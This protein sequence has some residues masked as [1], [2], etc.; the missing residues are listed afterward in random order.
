MYNDSV[1][2]L[3]S[4]GASSTSG[5]KKFQKL[6]SRDGQLSRPV[7]DTQDPEALCQLLPGDAEGGP[8]VDVQPEKLR[9]VH[10]RHILTRFGVFTELDFILH[11][12]QLA[13]KK[14]IEY[15]TFGGFSNDL[16]SHTEVQTAILVILDHK[17]LN[18]MSVYLHLCPFMYTV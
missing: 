16:K 3:R 18:N 6:I 4:M 8:V 12:F 9:Q 13:N 5:L 11:V 7:P 2:I 15:I 14:Y 1:S 10:L 17:F